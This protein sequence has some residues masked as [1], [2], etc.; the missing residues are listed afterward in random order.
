MQFHKCQIIFSL[1]AEKQLNLVNIEFLVHLVVS[2]GE[3]PM[4]VEF[5]GPVQQGVGRNRVGV[6]VSFASVIYPVFCTCF[7]QLWTNSGIPKWNTF[8]QIT[9]W[10]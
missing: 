10:M 1:D 6:P 4:F 3:L 7:F 8:L 9:V 2:L 5:L